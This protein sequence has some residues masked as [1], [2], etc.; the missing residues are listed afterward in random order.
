[1]L[2]EVI[3]LENKLEKS[4]ILVLTNEKMD[5]IIRHGAEWIENIGLVISDEIHLIGDE[6]RG[7]TLEMI[8]TQ[9]KRLENNPQIV[10][11]SYS[12]HYTKLYELP[13][14]L[15]TSWKDRSF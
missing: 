2:Y 12:I 15:K 11:T 14:R 5:S 9:L 8:L 4:N 6:S 10:I 1:M 7:P 3:T 13:S